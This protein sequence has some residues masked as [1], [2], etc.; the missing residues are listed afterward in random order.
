MCVARDSFAQKC[1]NF[2]PFSH[3]HVN[4]TLKAIISWLIL[5]E[6]H[7][8]TGL[9][10]KQCLRK[11]KKI[12]PKTFKL[13]LILNRFFGPNVTTL[14]YH[15]SALARTLSRK[16]SKIFRRTTL[17]KTCQNTGSLRAVFSWVRTEST[18]LSLYRK[19]RLWKSTCSGLF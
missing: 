6:K 19:M 11:F 13:E 4:N 1:Y 5:L 18:T 16:F 2:H 8:F 12:S 14:P 10:K 9:A 7:P 3:P 15:K 17:L